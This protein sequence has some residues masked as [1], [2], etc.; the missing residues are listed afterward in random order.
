MIRDR[1][2]SNQDSGFDI[3]VRYLV[4]TLF[5]VTASVLAVG[6]Q[7]EFNVENEEHRGLSNW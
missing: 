3:M 4:S 2:L 1:S 6:A 7:S 5:G